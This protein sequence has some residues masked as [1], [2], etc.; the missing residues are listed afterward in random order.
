MINIPCGK[1]V[2]DPHFRYRMPP[3][4]VKQEGKRT[5]I[6]NL[7]EVAKALRRPAFYLLKWFSFE[8]GT[9]QREDSL[10]GLH[11]SRELKESL[12]RFI[13]IFV[14]CPGCDGPEMD[15]QVC[16]RGRG[17]R[18]NCNG[19]GYQGPLIGKAYTGTALKL[20]GYAEKNPP[21]KRLST[22]GGEKSKEEK[23][24]EKAANQKAAAA[25]SIKKKNPEVV[26]SVSGEDVGGEGGKKGKKEKQKKS[27]KKS[28]SSS[29]VSS[30]S[31][32]EKAGSV[33]VS[34]HE[35]QTKKKKED[36]EVPSS[37]EDDHDVLTFTSPRIQ[38][39][40][41]ALRVSLCNPECNDSLLQPSDRVSLN[42]VAVF[43]EKLI[44]HQLSTGFD[45]R[46]RFFIL[47]SA[48]FGGGEGEGEGGE[49]SRFCAESVKERMPFLKGN[50]D[51]PLSERGLLEA[52]V[53]FSFL[54]SPSSFEQKGRR[55]SPLCL[56]VKELY[57]TD[58]V[59]ETA[60]VEFFQA[61]T[62]METGVSE[63][64]VEMQTEEAEEVL[65]KNA[66]RRG[67]TALQ[68]L[69]Q[70]FEEQ[71]EEEEEEEDSSSDKEE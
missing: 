64:G 1:A 28:S 41:S 44:N 62:E 35:S 14:I 12:D 70:W 36:I 11:S 69:L 47:L 60:V 42:T 16:S 5:R 55:P 20:C 53:A 13:Q 15:L 46:L 26:E 37:E 22:V 58:L 9:S 17:L 3:L 19:C 2:G 71:E 18:A 7:A 59:S 24:A 29:S 38:E 50:S 21:E 39:T 40:V 57:D 25:K 8:R 68:P 4:E 66:R 67:V 54:E 31:S 45:A 27:K 32:G 49:T 34:S 52:L 51:L 63:V 43:V 61:E 65:V 33:A 56:I 23:R 6:V 30:S 48:L 10:A